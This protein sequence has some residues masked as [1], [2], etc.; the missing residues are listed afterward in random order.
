MLSVAVVSCVYS[1]FPIFGGGE[2]CCSLRSF[3][4]WQSRR[5][6]FTGCTVWLLAMTGCI[7]LRCAFNCTWCVPRQKMMTCS[8]LLREF[9]GTVVFVLVMCLKIALPVLHILP[10]IQFFCWTVI[11]CFSVGCDTGLSICSLFASLVT[12]VSALSFPG[13]RAWDPL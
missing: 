3:R 7:L 10:S 8:C 12:R 4:S 13:I 1:V 9:T 6:C 5:K 11:I 2:R